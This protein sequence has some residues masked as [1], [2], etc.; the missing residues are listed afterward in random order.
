MG[1]EARCVPLAVIALGLSGVGCD[2]D[3]DGLGPVQTTAGGGA[4]GRDRGSVRKAN[5][6]GDLER[7]GI[8]GE[9][10]WGGWAAGGYGGGGGVGG[11]GGSGGVG[12]EGGG[13]GVGGGGGSGGASGVAQGPDVGAGAGG[14]DGA[15]DAGAGATNV[16][17]ATAAPPADGGESACPRGHPELALCLRF[18][19]KLVDDSQNAHALTASDVGFERG[20]SPGGPVNLVGRFGPA[21]GIAIPE[22]AALDSARATVE[23]WLNPR[24]LPLPGTQMGLVDNNNQYGVFL[25][26]DGTLVCIGRGTAAAPAVAR[27]GVWTSVACTFD[28]A[29]VAIWVN[30]VRYAEVPSLGPLEAAGTTGTSVGRDNPL[31]SNFDGLLDNVRVWRTVRTPEEIC[32]S[33]IVCRQ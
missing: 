27:P 17:A 18:E 9:G 29:R 8:G 13:G 2:L 21:G 4:S 6:V 30:G 31:G 15:P 26:P 23:A 19:G 11:G 28:E 3:L 7:A 20:V 5:R 12:G 16:D 22:S 10:A 33:A 1:I 14:G 24:A 25:R 32:W